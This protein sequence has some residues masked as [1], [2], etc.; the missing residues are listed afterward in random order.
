MSFHHS[1]RKFPN[2]TCIC[3]CVLSLICKW[4]L[5]IAPSN[6]LSGSRSYSKTIIF[7]CHRLILMGIKN[8][9][10]WYVHCSTLL[11]VFCHNF[12]QFMHIF[13]HV[14][15]VAEWLITFLTVYSVYGTSPHSRTPRNSPPTPRGLF[16]LFVRIRLSSTELQVN[17]PH[18]LDDYT[19]WS[20]SF[21]FRQLPISHFL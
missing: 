17:E 4:K 9:S 20:I 6:G 21:V 10:T 5:S 14:P 12:D 19:K 1:I 7:E 18:F 16:W 8:L 15:L 11:A 2:A 13:P 3:I